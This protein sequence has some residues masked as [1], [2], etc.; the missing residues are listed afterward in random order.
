MHVP[1]RFPKRSIPIPS[2]G[3]AIAIAIAGA[4]VFAAP[5]AMAATYYVDAAHANATDIGTG[6]GGSSTP[7]KTIQAAVTARAIGGNT[8]IVKPS[9]YRE[10]VALTVSGALKKLIVVK[11]SAPGVIVS[12]ADDFS[13]TN[14][15]TLVAGSVYLAS[16]VTWQP[17][18][19]F[20]SG[21]RLD[22]SSVAPASLSAN[23][24][25]YVN[26][27]GLYV[28]AGGGNPGLKNC[29]VGRRPVGI[30]AIAS[31]L[32]I[33]GFQ[34]TKTEDRGVYLRAGASNSI[35]Q[36]C[37]VTF[38]RSYGLHVDATTNAVV[39]KNTSSDNHDHG[40]SITASAGC[41][42]QNN[43]S[44]R[45]A[46]PSSRAATGI[47]VHS[48]PGAIVENNRCH[49]NQD[50]G[51]QFY[52]GSDN[53]ISRNNLSWNNG[54]HGYDHLASAGVMHLNDVAYGNFKD[55]FSIE[56][57]S[58]GGKM[59][60]C[61]AANN[62]LTV[63]E[64][65]LWVDAPSA[66]GF[67]SDYNVFWNGSNRSPFKIGATAYATLGA[68]QL[69]SGQDLHS[70][71]SNPL[72]IL[73]SAGNFRLMSNSP[74]IDAARSGLANGPTTDAAAAARYD[75]SVTPNL[76][77]GNPVYADIGAYEY[78][79]S[80]NRPVASLR[81]T[82]SKGESPLNVV[83]DASLSTDAN[84]AVIAYTFD[85]GDGTIVG[86]QT[87]PL[88][89]HTFGA[90]N[91]PVRLTATDAV[92]QIGTTTV[93][94]S[95]TLGDVKP[96]VVAPSTITAYRGQALQLNVTAS[97]I[98]SPSIT[99]LTANL[100][101]LP[102]GHNAVF[103]SN[104][105]HTAGTLTWTPVA[106]E[107]RTAPYNVT[108]TATNAKSASATTAI[109][110]EQPNAA[111]VPVLAATPQTG[112]PP[113][114]VT[115][116]AMG[117]FDPDGTVVSYRFD[118]GDGTVVGPQA[119]A[120][121]T[122]SYGLGNWEVRVTVVD[123]R[124]ASSTSA[125]VMVQVLGLGPNLVTN[126]SFE[127]GNT[128]WAI[129]GADTLYRVAG[130]QS[131][132]FALEMRA[133]AADT[134]L[135][136]CNDAPNWVLNAG[137][138]G[139]RY[140][141]T[142]W[143]RSA[144]HRGS[145]KLR[146]REFS[147]AVQN[148]FVR[149]SAGTVLSPVWQPITLEYNTLVS[150]AT[151]D[152]NVI[153][154]PIVAGETFQVDNISI[155][156]TSLSLP[157]IT[158][159]A[160][161]TGAENVPMSFTVAVSDPDGDPI[162]GLVADFTGL[163]VGHNATFVTNANRTE[164]TF[165]WTPGFA[166]AR[167]AIYPVNFIATSGISGA[168]SGTVPI[169]VTN[170][171]RAPAVASPAAVTV[172]EGELLTLV[173][174]A[175]DADG[176]TIT[177]LTANLAGLPA[178]HQ[179]VFTPNAARTAG[180]LSWTP[181]Y[182]DSG[183]Y[184]VSFTAANLMSGTHATVI[185]V[186]YVDRAPAIVAPAAVSGNE[187]APIV[188]AVTASDPDGEALSALT[189]ELSGLPAGH[190]AVFTS[191]PDHSAGSLS[192][193][194]TFAD[195]GTYAIVFTAANSLSATATSV[196][197]VAH[198]DRTPQM[199]S[200]AAVTAIEG[201]LLTVE[202]VAS[203]PDGDAITSLTADL[204]GLPLANNAVFT[205]NATGT[206]GTLTWTPAASAVRLAPYNVSFTVL[207]A[208]SRVS[209][210]A[211]TVLHPNT[212][213]TAVM[214]ATPQTG[215]EPVVVT[216]DASTS[217]DSDGT[218]ASYR[219]DFGDGTIV[220]PQISPVATHT[221]GLG[222]WNARVTVTD[223][224]GGVS[225]SSPVMIQVLG[226][227]A[228]LVRNPSIETNSSGWGVYGADTLSRVAGGQSGSF[229]LEM[230]SA[231]KST[232]LFGCND[233][234]NWVTNAGPAGT[235]YRLT[236]W[237][238]SAA[239][240][241]K[242][243]LRLREFSGTQQIG[244]TQLTAG[245]T[246]TPN[247]QPITFDYV[248]LAAGA[249]LDFNVVN[250]P[251]AP[252]EIFQ[253]D[254]IAIQRASLPL[255]VVNAPASVPGSEGSTITFAVTAADPSGD[256]ITGLTADFSSLPAG[257]G[258]TF[259]TN[260]ANTQGTFT[261]TPSYA[262][263][264]VSPYAVTFFAT[265]GASGTG[266]TSVPMAIANVD[267][268][269]LV[270]A[271]ATVGVSEAGQV[272]V[273]ITAVDPDGDAITTLTAD[274]SGLPASHAAVFTA[275]PGHGAGTLIW[276][277]TYSDSGT[278]AIVFTATNSRSTSA[279][280]VLHVGNVDRAPVVIAPVAAT[281][282]E[283]GLL[284][285]EIT[286]TDP[287]GD[288][289]DALVAGL[290]VL[291]SG[292]DAVF[293]P[294]P[295]QRG[296]TFTWTTSFASAG[297]YAIVFTAVNALS[298]S[299]TTVAHVEN[300]DR[301]PVVEAPAFVTA[302]EGEMVSIAIAASD[303]DGEVIARAADLSGLPSG[304]D[305][306]FTPNADGGRFTWTP[307]HADSGTYTLV[308]T[309]GNTLGDSAVTTLHIDNVDR[310][311]VVVVPSTIE[312]TDNEL[313]TLVFAVSDP[314]GDAITGFTVDRAALPI[315]NDAVFEPAA[316]HTGGTLT[317]TPT[318]ADA[319]G[320]Y[321]IAF[322]AE[323]ALIMD[324]VATI[325]VR[326]FNHPPQVVAPAV[327]NGIEGATL[328]LTITASD[329][330]GD[331]IAALQA[332]LSRL[333]AGSDAVFTPNGDRTEGT[334]T[335]TPTHADAEASYAVTFTAR[336]GTGVADADRASTVTTI[337]IGNVDRAP[338]VTAPPTVFLAET[339]A[340]EIAVSA[341]DPDGDA[342]DVLS[343]D[344]SGL[345]PGNDAQFVAHAGNASG[346]L[347]W[348]PTEGD[349]AGPFAITFTAG[350]ALSGS[351]Q[352]AVS[353]GRRP[354]ITVEPAV[355]VAERQQLSLTIT[356]SDPDGDAIDSLTADL[357]GI[358][359]G[360]VLFTVG[361]DRISAT[362]TWTPTFADARVAPYEVS[363][364]ATNGLSGSGTVAITV[365]NVDRAPIVTVQPA[366]STHEHAL[367][368]FTV[369]ASDPDGD[370]I[371]A[372]TA[373]LS[374]LPG[375][376]NATFIAGGDA[377]TGTFDWTPAIGMG[378]VAPYSVTFTAT[379]ALSDSDST[380]IVVNALPVA[381]LS[382][383][384]PSGVAPFTVTANA[385]GSSDLDG[386]IASYTFNFGDGTVVGPQATPIVTHV[387][388]TGTFTASVVVIDDKG[389]SA[390]TSQVVTAVANL[391]GNAGFESAASGWSGSGS[392]A[393]SR[394]VGGRTGGYCLNVRGPA[395]NATFGATDS[396][397][398]ITVTP[399]IATKYRFTAWVRSDAG[400]G[401]MKIK[402]REYLSGALQG[403]AGFSAPI[404]LS[405][406]WQQVAYEFTC[407]RAGSTLDFEMGDTPAAP[408]ESFQM[409]DVTISI[410]PAGPMAAMSQAPVF[411]DFDLAFSSTV[412]PNPIRDEGQLR[413]TTTRA[414]RVRIDFFDVSGRV[415]QTPFDAFVGPGRHGVPIRARGVMPAGVYFYRVDAAEGV[416]GGRIVVID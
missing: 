180:T 400:R 110:V 390:T 394:V 385:A 375:G 89:N 136:G 87:S 213:P 397:N 371:A 415:V 318:S 235:R 163:P 401:N 117:S 413:F 28:N 90:G 293:T 322:R 268:A 190:G 319:P 284:S 288:A 67:V 49:D 388:A 396:P 35:V 14:R 99:S 410:V 348:T 177:S 386:T 332:D 281:V 214:T 6:A 95:V 51:I 225:I 362:L 174:N 88:A 133:A 220:G 119:S 181:S 27:T 155:Q 2:I 354:V 68:Y 129:Y 143:V 13:A 368:H 166:H 32:T 321:T 108:F 232:A 393:V 169:V 280:T 275:D 141:F 326:R 55:G 21:A 36:N 389:A 82:P 65:D 265:S 172:T 250:A 42:V 50:S 191:S 380:T 242:A 164:G 258:A 404:A 240:R 398:W 320:S 276:N 356:A 327:A 97:D 139:T 56:G 251:I 223:D 372:L 253:A 382:M 378:R 162:T 341:S 120:T 45:N 336:T 218:V 359:A 189:A 262:D 4:L 105:S 361:A 233:S 37:T 338:V 142:A 325:L 344:L 271:P 367:V 176:D 241:G 8:I 186:R 156:Q 224:R 147:G 408:G 144:A 78:R 22:T 412:M 261:W 352:S 158:M 196:L 198:V 151:L 153:D 205:P 248:T 370:S 411:V 185:T 96:V 33:D 41:K 11:A 269:P 212:M 170:V 243:K 266:S 363:F 16:S 18:Q 171:D 283:N 34:V 373:N 107:V 9:I 286:A 249:S 340:L 93:I 58:P 221:Y 106:S 29:E 409:D 154:D 330:D 103:T 255:P 135:F 309:A 381:V 256:P 100:S 305:A 237:V 207:N 270:I 102:A 146:L 229:A 323:N 179:A 157:V 252:G 130:G 46:R 334:L 109:G 112:A 351:A 159:P 259:V 140:R 227:G 161:V 228:N 152:F 199:T 299:S 402:V 295:D 30:D 274:L 311:P 85:F 416:R 145:A 414:G 76:G 38:A 289:I 376:S 230:R 350:N 168:A 47:N 231:S 61:I 369:T 25:R 128:G 345:P 328:T 279:T 201:G 15:W 115:A 239:H 383:T 301:S 104:A 7:Y 188:I 267:P 312:V 297:N 39:L 173:V 316:D 406:N 84:G 64:Y 314:D 75:D 339:G 209:S 118:F 358:P 182:A 399:A 392:A 337:G 70:R 101:G 200:P 308:F 282:S 247:W 346:T 202:I 294:A 81:L 307:S 273:A 66:V 183:I 366:V 203:D 226:L 167:D 150:G 126:N 384:P 357:A 71:Q 395:T 331:A 238:R 292:S 246:L 300:V 374:A 91:W 222:N 342:I 333:P 3:S 23:T 73:P 175:A 26:G 165:T 407:A 79:P 138:A 349:G 187:G 244:V 111:P 193:S 60:N 365:S 194:P 285:M 204:S 94:D 329:P 272:T 257:H 123:D 74:A 208:L 12:G 48:S 43:E 113:M 40:I 197:H 17:L 5:D 290:A 278:Y 83:A 391:C 360:D 127:T 19:V 206:A 62:G 291:P 313:L 44:M 335:W 306:V 10:S 304:G 217:F 287:D 80:G 324:G 77:F 195:S 192:W 317:W 343:A 303:P 215:S 254:N 121:A 122:H 364:R 184:T 69:A 114:L 31:Y 20:A 53:G 387:Y 296:G 403:A 125:P 210:T 178:G 315:V 234:P 263:A 277:P 160:A 298:G 264:R 124:G 72:F 1:P 379:N 137:A 57:N 355:T 149:L 236:A 302:R 54:D 377:T 63:N 132:N 59:Y 24:F 347:T 216:A 92:G 116:S 131:G 211:I 134:G 245:V 52:N 219:F 86:P 260:A 98:D 353:R 405:S 310:A 148:G